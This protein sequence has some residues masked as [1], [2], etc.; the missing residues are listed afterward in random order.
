MSNRAIIEREL[1][2]GVVPIGTPKA[3]QYDQAL[4]ESAVATVVQGLTEIG[5]Y[6][7]EK[8]SEYL[9]YATT[10]LQAIQNQYGYPFVASTVSAMTD[11][12][13]IYVYTGSESGY[14]AGNWYYYDGNAWVS[15]GVF[16]STE[17]GVKA[18]MSLFGID[19]FLWDSAT[20]PS[21]T[22]VTSNGV[23]YTA[24]TINKTVTVSTGEGSSTG[25]T[26]FRFRSSGDGFPS[27]AVEGQEYIAHM[28]TSANMTL[29]IWNFDSNGLASEPLV[30][31]NSYQRFTIPVGCLGLV[32]RL[33]VPSDV[34]VNTVVRPF[35]SKTL[36]LDEIAYGG[37]NKHSN[38]PEVMTYWRPSVDGYDENN[39]FTTENMPINSYTFIVGSR[40]S[41]TN[42]TLDPLGYYVIS[43]KSISSTGVNRLYEILQTSV[44][45]PRHYMAISNNSG[46]TVNAWYELPYADNAILNI[47]SLPDNTDLNDLTGLVV[48]VLTDSRTYLNAPFIAGTIYNLQLTNN[49]AVQYGFQFTN[50]TM[51]YRKCTGGTWASWIKLTG[52]EITNNYTTNHYSNTYNVTA[53]PTITTDT[54]NFLASTND[55]TDRTADIQA[56]LSSTG[57]CHLGTGVFYVTGVDVPAYKSLE[58]CGN[59]TE[60][61]LASSV[62]DGYAVKL[63]SYSTVKNVMISGATSDITLTGTVGT[64]HG[65]LFEGNADGDN[66]AIPQRSTISNVT[67]RRF[68]GGGITCNNTGYPTNGMNISDVNIVNC[69]AGVNVAYWSEF[70]R[71]TNVQAT[72]CYY[73]CINNGGNNMFAN[74]NFSSNTC[75]ILMDDQYDQSPNNSHGSYVG[76][77]INHSGNNTGYAIKMYGMRNGHIFS[78]CQIFFGKMLFD[79]CH[80]IRFV[81]CNIG[82][83]TDIDISDSSAI[84]YDSCQFRVAEDTPVTVTNSTGVHFNNCYLRDGTAFDPLA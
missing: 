27:W 26:Y 84:T 42:I 21:G 77:V 49:T 83:T 40:F 44:R 20:Y 62:T 35:I 29:Q 61:I 78:G 39:P 12:T 66:D 71:F 65:I 70:H 55:T 48:C 33:H 73:G 79:D 46:A 58:G 10:I 28:E 51:W 34:A 24:D 31:T 82:R 4:V 72:Y 74:C 16:N 6:T 25:V 11:I 43:C 47:G 2:Q 7:E 3:Y 30:D 57:C 5:E 13:K 15:G 59:A 41:D 68:S 1:T 53:T 22:T 8:K 67:I 63:N 81:G 19:D 60:I 69:E 76:C 64:R 38:T 56:M 14:T 9:N 75:G 54:N 36:T 45:H 52:T 37:K 23:T 50:G 80:G 17:S 18:E 32:I